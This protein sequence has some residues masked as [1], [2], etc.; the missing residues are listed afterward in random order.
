MHQVDSTTFPSLF[1]E[2]WR[3][4]AGVVLKFL[5]PAVRSIQSLPRV[6]AA[7]EW[8][9]PLVGDRVGNDLVQVILWRG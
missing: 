9:F 2:G 8:L 7:G 6:I 1:K 5:L 3:V 4:S